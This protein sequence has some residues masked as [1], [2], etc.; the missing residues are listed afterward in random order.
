MKVLF[1]IPT[2]GRNELAERSVRSAFGQSLRPDEVRVVEDA[3]VERP[4]QWVGEEK[5]QVTRNQ[6]RGGP[7]IGRNQMMLESDADVFIGLDDDSHFL[8]R[9]VIEKACAVF[10]EKPK[11]GALYFEVLM[12]GD[13]QRKERGPLRQVR[14]FVGCGCALR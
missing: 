10:A 2:S 6:K 7:M 8:D 1:G 14:T 5:V 9:D 12:E 4:F 13:E 11:V 3:G